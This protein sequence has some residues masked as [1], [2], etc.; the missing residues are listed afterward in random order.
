MHQSSLGTLMVIAGY[1][2]SPLW[3]TQ[4]LPLFFLLSAVSMGFAVVVFESIVSS[5]AFRRPFE[6]SMLAK[7]A[8]V[9]MWLLVVYLGLRFLDLLVRGQLGL[10]FQGN[11]ESFMFILENALYVV[12]VLLL[13]S[14]PLRSNLRWLFVA[15]VSM[16][17]AGSLYRFNAFLIGF[18]P[19]PGWTYFPALPEIFITLGIVAFELMA[20]LYFVK[21]FPV[22]PK[23]EH[24]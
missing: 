5:L 7:I 4:M 3:Q 20:Y 13:A 2:L 9:I 22:L 15:S 18:N 14:R 8:A 6:T 19:G 12:P 16:L 1:K 17:L 21:R 11:S 24:A 10:I 23:V